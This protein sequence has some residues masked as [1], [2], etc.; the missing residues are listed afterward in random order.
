MNNQQY[1]HM[2]FYMTYPMPMSYQDDD[3]IE[4]DMEYMK[5]LYP[6]IARKIQK[7]VEEACDKMDFAGSRMY[8]EYPDKIMLRKV[9]RDI[10]DKIKDSGDL[11]FELT[12]LTADT[13]TEEGQ[14]VYSMNYVPYRRCWDGSCMVN[15]FIEILLF[16]EIF[17]RRR[18]RPYW[19]PYW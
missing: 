3:V 12:K 9:A 6:D 1:P 16:N 13:S 15:D 14:D 2:P 19:R 7:H 10:F 4:K 8:D 11:Q 5:E 18:R 17:R